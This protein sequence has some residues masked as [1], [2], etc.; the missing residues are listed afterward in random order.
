MKNIHDAILRVKLEKTYIA[1]SALSNLSDEAIGLG[2]EPYRIAILRNFTVE[3]LI[4]VLKGEAIRLGLAPDIYIGDFDAIAES[5]MNKESDLYSFNP[6]IIYIAQWAEAISPALTTKFLSLTENEV[7]TE[8]LRL[9]SITES[10]FQSIRE[11]CNVP[12]VINNF[13]NTNLATLGV[14]DYQSEGYQNHTLSKLNQML[15]KMSKKFSDIYW[16]DMKD[17]FSQIG[18]LNSF[19]ERS[20]QTARA[21]LS[22]YSL[23]PTGLEY[24]KFIR[25]LHGKT[26]KCLV[27][28]CDNTLWG[29]IVGED[30]IDGIKL[31]VDYPGA[32]FLAFQQECLNLYNRG[33][34]LAL[35]SKN[36]EADVLQVFAEHKDCI[37]KQ[38]HF[39]TWQINWDDKA[40]NLVRIAENLN[41]GID[42]LVFVDDNLFEC[43]WVLRELPQVEVVNLSKYPHHYRKELLSPGFFDSLTFSSEDKK[44]SDLYVQDNYR[45]RILKNATSF[46][47]YLNELGLEAEVGSPCSTDIQR[48]SQLTQKTNQYNLTTHR[49]TEGDVERFLNSDDKEV[50][51]LRLKD[52]ISD[53]GLIGVAIIQ[54]NGLVANIDSFMMSCRALGRG[55][56][57]V[58]MCTIFKRSKQRGCKKIVG[59]YIK[60]KKNTQVADFYEKQN[61]KLLENNGENTIW[62]TSIEGEI[63][64]YPRWIAVKE[65]DY[66]RI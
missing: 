53:L 29:G 64:E 48:I 62:E 45:K 22:K 55:S 58:L 34:I 5:V 57:D 6:N 35:C 21:P 9:I 11:Q 24:A 63:K 36:N 3:P 26:R 43:E 17:I 40:T 32:S 10:W 51:Y 44:R 18:Y 15:L 52:R 2:F 42:S 60:T 28:D 19:D 47:S 50:L 14:L 61:F 13:L 33:V 7:E 39:A 49:Y 54:Y 41:I 12:V 16:V 65:K 1:Y 20:W 56:E 23:L 38:H 37:L 4:P 27:L 31:G 46:E 30:G 66:L 59:T 8:V 25:A